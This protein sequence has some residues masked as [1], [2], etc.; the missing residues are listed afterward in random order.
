MEEKRPLVLLS[1]ALSLCLVLS[2]T[3][4][5]L[6]YNIIFRLWYETAGG[7]GARKTGCKGTETGQDAERR[8]KVRGRQN[9]EKGR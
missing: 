1:V 9:S 6:P 3:V 7:T 4:S 8:K 2:L 5:L